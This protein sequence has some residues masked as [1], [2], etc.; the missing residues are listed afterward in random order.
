MRA[1]LN[2]GLL[3]YE[4]PRFIGTVLPEEGPIL[5][6]IPHLLFALSGICLVVGRLVVYT[7]AFESLAV[8]GLIT[9]A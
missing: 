2:P 8:T 4:V 6:L 7:Q 9:R 1:S 5:N 3:Q